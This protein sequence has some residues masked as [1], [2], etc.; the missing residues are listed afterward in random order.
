[1]VVIGG[2]FGGLAVAKGLRKAP[3]SVTLIDRRNHHLFQPLLYQVATA[4]LAPGDIAEPI[5]SILASQRNVE[6]MLG[7]AAKI[8]TT[9]QH[10]ELTDGRKIPYDKLVVAAGA[11]HGYFG[12]DEWAAHAPGI[13]TIGDALEMRRKLLLAFERAEWTTDA[14]ER[15]RLMTFAIIGGGPTG[16]ELAGSIREIASISMLKDFRH[17]DTT[18]TRVLLVEAGDA[19]LNGYPDHLRAKAKVQLEELGVEVRLGKAVT[20]VDERGL[21]IGDERIETTNVFWAAGVKAEPIGA[22]LGA[23]MDR[24]G[25]VQVEP[26]LSVPGHPDVF[27]IGDLA[28][29]E[30][31]GKPLPGVAQVAMQAGDLV[32]ANIWADMEKKPRGTFRY[33]DVGKMATIGVRRAVADIPG[34]EFSGFFAWLFWALIHLFVLVAFRNRVVVFAKWIMSYVTH[35]RG[36]RLLWQVEGWQVTKVANPPPGPT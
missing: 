2:G 9:A 3:V 33:R 24:A 34:L 36:S 7:E 5:R 32:A 6:V 25:R 22:A 26:D 20:L 31:D 12:H 8:D 19:L 27:V 23:P 10:V 16:V 4:G 13:K 14:A 30:Q 29:F 35:D 15:K 21:V 18:A 11:T 28:A 1:M 17:I